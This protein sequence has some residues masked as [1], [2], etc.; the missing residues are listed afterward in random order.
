MVLKMVG[1]WDYFD[2]IEV[3]MLTKLWH[4]EYIGSS[5]KVLCKRDY[6]ELGVFALHSKAR[7][8]ISYSAGK[9]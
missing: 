5:K 6:L 2:N 1:K 9:N 7:N 8:M 3:V 4:R